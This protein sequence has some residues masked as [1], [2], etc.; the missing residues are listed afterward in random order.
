RAPPLLFPY[1]TLFRSCLIAFRHITRFFRLS[2]IIYPSC[3]SPNWCFLL[4]HLYMVCLYLGTTP[5][6]NFNPSRCF[7]AV[8]HRSWRNAK[9]RSEEHTSELQSRF[10]F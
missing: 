1:T 9:S 4:H 6:E 8:P 3:L 5:C 10:D 7:E 2:L